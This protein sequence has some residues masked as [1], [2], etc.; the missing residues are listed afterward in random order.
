M[1][2]LTNIYLLSMILSVLYAVFFYIIDSI[3]GEEF[4][5]GLVVSIV[6]LVNTYI[7]LAAVILAVSHLLVF[8][9]DMIYIVKSRLER[10][11][12]P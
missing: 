1:D 3:D 12:S 7:A 5:A 9:F 11:H 6:P 4:F 10:N 8:V 2:T